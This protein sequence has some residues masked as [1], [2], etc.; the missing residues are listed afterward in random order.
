MNYIMAQPRFLEPILSGAK[1]HTIRARK[2]SRAKNLVGKIISI[3][4]WTGRPYFSKQKEIAQTEV[5]F[6]FSIRITKERIYRLDLKKEPV[7]LLKGFIAVNDG[8]K[9]W[10]EMRDWFKKVHGLPFEGV[11]I[12]WKNLIA[13]PGGSR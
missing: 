13:K 4:I 12:H 11:L 1:S 10:E 6:V 3:R 9:N 7:R 5:D 8:F 2:L